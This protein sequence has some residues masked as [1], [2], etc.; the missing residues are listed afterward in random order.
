MSNLVQMAIVILAALLIYRFRGRIMGALSRFDARAVA[1]HQEE[2]NDRADQ[3]A[4]FKHTLRLAE[5]QVETVQEVSG[6]DEHTAA[7]VTRFVFEGE[8]FATRAEAEKTRQD[9]I[10]AIARGF[11][12]ELPRAL[13][14][15]RNG[16]LGN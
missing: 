2:M 12:M 4:H 11:Y 13:A 1:R 7:P 9:K 8:Q 6:H 10:R 5:E 15:R 14:E 3:L 16:K